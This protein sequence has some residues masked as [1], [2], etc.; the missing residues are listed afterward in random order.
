M[1]R[2]PNTTAPAPS[3]VERR[4]K[5]V[6]GAF[7]EPGDDD[8]EDGDAL[9]IPLPGLDDPVATAPGPDDTGV[10]PPV[11]PGRPEPEPTVVPIGGGVKVK[12]NAGE[13]L[14]LAVARPS[15][16]VTLK[17]CR[18]PGSVGMIA[19]CEGNNGAR[20]EAACSSAGAADDGGTILIETPPEV[21]V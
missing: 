4:I 1:A 5:A 13:A 10:E 18:R 7:T 12:L 8:E 17:P 11:E 16:M 19:A 9:E 21:A 3:G 14:A 15:V 2:I 20:T 6:A